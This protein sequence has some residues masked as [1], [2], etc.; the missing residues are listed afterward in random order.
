MAKMAKMTKDEAVDVIQAALGQKIADKRTKEH[1]AWEILK[2]EL[3]NNEDLLLAWIEEELEEYER[4]YG[5]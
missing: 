4:E 5:K 1:K 2:F 3:I